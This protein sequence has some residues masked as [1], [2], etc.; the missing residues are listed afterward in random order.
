MGFLRKLKNASFSLF[1][2]KLDDPM[3]WIVEGVGG[4]APSRPLPEPVFCGLRSPF[5]PRE[6]VSNILSW[7]RRVGIPSLPDYLPPS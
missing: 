3:G 6:D 1:T 7:I 5:D 4:A 2:S